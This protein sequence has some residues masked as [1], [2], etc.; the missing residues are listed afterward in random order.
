[1][2]TLAERSAAIADLIASRGGEFVDG[3]IIGPPPSP[4]PSPSPSP[5]LQ[6]SVKLYLSGPS[7]PRFAEFF[8]DTVVAT[9]IVGPGRTAASALKISYAAWT[10]GIIALVIATREYAETEGI[11]EQL[12]AEWR[13]S[14]PPVGGPT[15]L[16]GERGRREGVALG[17]RDER[18]RGLL[19]RRWTAR[20]VPSRGGRGLRGAASAPNR[21]PTP[22]ASGAKLCGAV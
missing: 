15:R 13:A 5:S 2:A 16:C 4:R 14:M 20:R 19:R 17:R 9:P 11:G 6:G 22:H 21:G 7:S 8:A 12:L 18:D 1:V 10:K 3:G